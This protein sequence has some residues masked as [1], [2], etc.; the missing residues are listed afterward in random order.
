MAVDSEKIH[1]YLKQHEARHIAR[2][3]EFIQQP[4]I[5]SDGVGVE[6][7]LA[8][9]MRYLR[10]LGCQ[11]VESVP[12]SGGGHPGVFAYLDAGAPRTLINY[13]MLD[14][15]PAPAGEWKYPPF[16]AEIVEKAPFGRVLMGRGAQ[17]RKGPF[18]TW[19]NALE[20]LQAVE[21]KLP[22][23]ILFLAEA[24]ENQGSPHYAEFVTR[25][26]D[27]LAAAEAAFCPGAV[28]TAA[29]EMKITLG[30]KGLLYLRLRASGKAWGKGPQGAPSHAMSAGLVESPTWR[31]V[32]ALNTLYDPDARRVLVEDFYHEE[33][34]PAASEVA[35]AQALARQFGDRPWKLMLG[36]L[37][38]NVK[39]DS[40]GL[41]AEEAILRYW[42]TPTFNITG[43]SAGYTGPGTK[44]F[45]LPH[46]AW[47][48]LDIRLP[49][50]YSPAKTIERLRRHLEKQGFPDI[51][52]EVVAAHEPYRTA[53]DSDLAHSVLSLCEEDGIPVTLTPYSGGG[54][55]WSL[56]AAMGK[57]V[58]FDVGPGHGAGAGAADEFLALDGHDKV[59]GLVDSELFFARFL[60]RWA[61][62]KEGA[63]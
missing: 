22:V 27:R 13:I 15:K 40:D 34:A 33:Q 42:F 20:A 8:L 16:G 44:V 58:L 45:T 37:G 11:E 54:G 5:P 3:Q 39:G 25:Y 41:S 63:R 18:I 61:H 48:L 46:E 17:G 38:P 26:Q 2:M 60:K 9:L 52:V 23:N 55:P 6:E 30:Y 21:G 12:A 28:Q 53:V 59:Q 43:L 36:G 47:V 32:S 10:E 29:G 35:E 56:F 19:L 49:R 31:L 7:S 1:Q 50:G 14:T 4:C 57:P 62:L 51:A 24:E